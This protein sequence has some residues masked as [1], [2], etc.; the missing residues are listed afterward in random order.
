MNISEHLPRWIYSSC[1]NYFDT[2]RGIYNF[3]IEDSTNPSK[4]PWAE[5]RMWGPHIVETSKN[6]FKI[7]AT[8]NLLLSITNSEFAN[9]RLHTMS[10]HF[11]KKFG[12]ISIYK[13]DDASNS[14]L[15]INDGSLVGCLE[16]K[17]P[18]EHTVLGK[19][20]GYIRATLQGR[21]EMFVDV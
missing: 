12:P 14:N 5:F 15:V 8:V 18:V 1:A 4:S 10:G 6:S 20:E 7:N 19:L 11:M 13:N 2:N 21:Y 16:L 3:R 17:T 9:Y